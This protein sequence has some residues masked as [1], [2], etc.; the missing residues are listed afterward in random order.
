[1]SPVSL[2]WMS[3]STHCYYKLNPFGGEK[4]VAVA[5]VSTGVTV[6]GEACNPIKL[7]DSHNTNRFA[8]KEIMNS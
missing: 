4:T 3:L 1:M 5:G 7:I 6:S 2:S 8:N